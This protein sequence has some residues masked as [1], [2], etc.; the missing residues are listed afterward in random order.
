MHQEN[1]RKLM[2][3]QNLAY[4]FHTSVYYTLKLQQ[5]EQSSLQIGVQDEGK[6]KCKHKM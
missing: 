3:V 2:P 5:L 6:L 4:F 1:A